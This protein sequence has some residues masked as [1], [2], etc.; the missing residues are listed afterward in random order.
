M[1]ASIGIVSIAT[2]PQRGQ[3]IADSRIGRD[4]IA[5][6]SDAGAELYADRIF[7]VAGATA[8]SGLIDPV[9]SIVS[10]Y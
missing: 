1:H 2:A 7:L 6:S 3:V 9:K 5:D 4:A 10:H 8:E